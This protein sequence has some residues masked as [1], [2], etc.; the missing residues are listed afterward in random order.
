MLEGVLSTQLFEHG[1]VSQT[2]TAHAIIC[3]AVQVYDATELHGCLVC[4]AE[5]EGKLFEDV[6]IY[7]CQSVMIKY[8]LRIIPAHQSCACHR[9][10]VCR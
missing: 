9:I 7:R 10:Q 6:S 2:G 3:D 5:P 4:F 8:D 1:Q